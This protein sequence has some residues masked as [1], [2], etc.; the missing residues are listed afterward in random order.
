MT[1]WDDNKDFFWDNS[2][3]YNRKFPGRYVTIVNKKIAHV[4][5]NADTDFKMWSLL[6]PG[7]KLEAYTRY[8]PPIGEIHVV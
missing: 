2:T 4:A 1:K 3:E 7:D 5:G 8:I 6:R